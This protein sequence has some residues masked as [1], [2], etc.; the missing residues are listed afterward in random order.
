[1]ASQL[2]ARRSHAA[3]FAL[4]LLAACSD[5]LPSAPGVPLPAP[6]ADALAVLRC[7]AQ[8]RPA[9]VTCAPDGAAGGAQATILGG[10]GVNVRLTASNFENDT[11]A[12]LFSMDVT[13]Q[14]LLAT[15]MGAADPGAVSGVYVFFYSGPASATGTVDV[16]QPDGEGV[17]TAAGQA[18]FHWPEVLPRNGVSQPRRWRFSVS[19]SVQ[20]FQFQVYVKTE[21]MP[22]LVF[23]LA[24]GGNRDIYRMA[25]DG[26][27]LL[28]LTTHAADDRNPSASRSTVVFATFRHGKSEIYSVPLAGGAETR[29]TTTAA[30]EGD[31]AL[32]PDGLRLAYTSDAVVGVSKVWTANPDGTGAVRATR[33]SFGSDAEPEA[34]PAWAPTG[35]RLAL[36]AT[37]S[38]SADVYDFALGGV[39]SLLAGGTTAEVDPAWS[40]DGTR[41]VYTSNVT[42]AG[43]VYMLRLSDGQVTRLTSGATAES[44]ATWTGNGRIV[45][46]TFLSGG[47]TELR[48][49]NPDV[50]GSGG[51]IPVTG[52]PNRPHAVPF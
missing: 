35:N 26:S 43:D 6:P 11:A 36:V 10:Q 19:K 52:A 7:T 44:Y 47:G 9:V 29:L 1:M 20:S 15:P 49:L 30:S 17:F 45:Y 48:W 32:S 21:L 37:A 12:G 16:Y 34:A 25:M 27:D 2:S 31:P 46:L 50:P 5:A 39:P 24:A 33:T 42:G 41:V 28:R 8:V 22:L 40:P 38:G 51:V 13:V 3:L 18:Y 4:L 14:N 23:D